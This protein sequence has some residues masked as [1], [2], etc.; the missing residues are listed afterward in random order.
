M[1]DF[2][3]KHIRSVLEREIAPHI[4]QGDLESFPAADRADQLLSRSLAAYALCL[5]A[6]ILPELAA[7]HVTD[8]FHDHGIDA[9]YFDQL[10]H[11]VFVVQ[12]KWTHRADKGLKA[13]DVRTFTDGFRDLLNGDFTSFNDRFKA[14]DSELNSAIADPGATFTLI[15]A[16]T[17]A[18]AISRD[19]REH[20]DRFLA[21]LNDAKDTFSLRVYSQ[22]ELHDAVAKRAEG[23]PVSLQELLLHE[24]SCIREPYVAYQG[25][26]TALDVARWHDQ[27]KEKLFR[28]NLRHVI[29]ASDVNAAMAATLQAEPQHFWYFNNGITIICDSI[30]LRAKGG[31]TSR[32]PKSLSCTGVNIV[33]GAQTVGAIAMA[34]AKNPES[35]QD[36]WVSVRL[37]SLEDCPPGFAEA[38]TRATNTQNSITNR[39]FAALDEHQRRLRRDL[40]LDGKEY[41]IRTGEVDVPPPP[42][43][44][45][46]IDEATI[47][48]ACER[49]IALAVI[50]KSTI[51]RVWENTKR[52]PYTYLFNAKLSAQHLWKAVEVLRAV[53]STL[54][55]EQAAHTGRQKQAAIHGNRFITHQVFKRLHAFHGSFDGVAKADLEGQVAGLTVEALDATIAA[56]DTKFRAAYLQM[57]FKS[58]EKCRDLDNEIDNP[59]KN[60]LPPPGANY[61]LPLTTTT[62]RA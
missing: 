1:S 18:R 44:G 53:D 17:G 4:D 40:Q 31:G 20:M 8:G 19:V 52:A 7:K 51:G 5:T 22:A 45:C 16:Y 57:F 26:V 12:S 60:V 3:L 61:S 48:L 21:D 29:P 35:L 13:S 33:N 55:R 15:L 62:R 30:K 6:D 14:L 49:D 32:A 23:A 46:T 59:A 39:D 2:H 56:L 34:N 37:V 38:I 50:A 27:H 41:A 54:L 11:R 9:F 42:D 24:W 47:A 43:R 25:Q 58:R 10:E 28:K 36:A